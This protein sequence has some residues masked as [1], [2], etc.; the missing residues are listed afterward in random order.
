MEVERMQ[1]LFR[2]RFAEVKDKRPRGHQW[3][4]DRESV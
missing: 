3:N 4:N 1:P 2:R